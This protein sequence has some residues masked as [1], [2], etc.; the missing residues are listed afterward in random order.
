[1]VPLG[2]QTL[3]FGAV[4]TKLFDSFKNAFHIK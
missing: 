1:M 2:S 4:I 3:M